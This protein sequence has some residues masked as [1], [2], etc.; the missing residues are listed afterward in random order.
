MLED[1]FSVMIMISD[2]SF[3]LRL[4]MIFSM[5]FLDF[6]LKFCPAAAKKHPRSKFAEKVILSKFEIYIPSKQAIRKR[7]E[8]SRNILLQFI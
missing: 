4:I 3:Q 5:I 6:I 1:L 2:Y 8:I 7:A